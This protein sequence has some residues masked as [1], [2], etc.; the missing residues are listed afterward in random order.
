MTAQEQKRRFIEA[1]TALT[2][3]EAALILGLRARDVQQVI[4]PTFVY[5]GRPKYRQADVL[6][7]RDQ[8]IKATERVQA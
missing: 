6:K 8:L 5:N 2:Q 7:R 1:E 4:K 3:T